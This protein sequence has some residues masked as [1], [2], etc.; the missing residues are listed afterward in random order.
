MAFANITPNALTI[1]SF[2]EA[3][4]VFTAL[5]AQGANYGA[6]FKMTGRR[7]LIIAKNDNDDTPASLLSAAVDAWGVYD[8]DHYPGTV[9]TQT[10]TA[11]TLKNGD[12]ARIGYTLGTTEATVDC[13]VVLNATKWSLTGV[14]SEDLSIVIEKLVESPNTITVK[15][16]MDAGDGAPTLSIDTIIEIKAT[17]FLKVH[18]GEFGVNDLTKQPFTGESYLYL[19]LESYYFKK[20]ANTGGY[21]DMAKTIAHGIT[22]NEKGYCFITGSE[23]VS[24]AVFEM[25]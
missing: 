24:V 4:A 8:T 5:T 20:L 23:D 14:V 12:I 15:A 21:A 6:T 3:G 17:N 25:I 13:T 1:N 10:F 16:V 2:D 18:K 7:Y 19:E 22:M 9:T 11:T